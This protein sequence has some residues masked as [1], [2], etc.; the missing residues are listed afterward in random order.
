MFYYLKLTRCSFFPPEP[1]SAVE[2]G[3][4]HA[5]SCGTAPYRL[6]CWQ[7]REMTSPRKIV[8]G[9]RVLYIF[10]FFFCGSFL[11]LFFCF[12]FLLKFLF[13]FVHSLGRCVSFFKHFKRKQYPQLFGQG[14]KEEEK[15]E[16]KKTSNI[17]RFDVDKFTIAVA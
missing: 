9:S 6:R 12:F 14:E 15:K 13:E 8:G 16:E 17:D 11:S 4:F 5:R 7:A 3:D 1:P 2:S 10:F